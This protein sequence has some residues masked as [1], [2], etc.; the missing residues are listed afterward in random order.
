MGQYL[1]VLGDLCDIVPRTT[2]QSEICRAIV[3][4][5]LL[6]LNVS[7][8]LTIDGVGQHREVHKEGF[9]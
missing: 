3:P 6:R 7:E 9:D 1:C 4:V 5:I 2:W 8:T